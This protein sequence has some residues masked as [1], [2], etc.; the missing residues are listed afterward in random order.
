MWLPGS[1]YMQRLLQKTL[2]ILLPL[3]IAVGCGWRFRGQMGDNQVVIKDLL[4]TASPATEN[5]KKDIAAMLI[6]SGGSVA[7]DRGNASLIL[8]LQSLSQ[9]KIKLTEDASGNAKMYQLKMEIEFV[10]ATVQQKPEEQAVQMVSRSVNLQ[11]DPDNILGKA[12]EEK[13]LW[14]NLRNEI[15]ILI[16][17]RVNAV[18]NS[19][20]KPD[21]D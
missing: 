14:Q 17:Q 10:I 20:K 21:A 7:S 9:N 8:S 4:I 1:S 19:G 16:L 13:R 11:Y 5:L 12:E 15:A 6:G 2:I 3:L 18:A